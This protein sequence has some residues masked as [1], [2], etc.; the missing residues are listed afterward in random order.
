[1][2]FKTWLE[3]TKGVVTFDF[4]CTL[5]VPVWDAENELWL[6]GNPA[7][8]NHLNPKNIERLRQYARDGYT[9][10]IV[11]SRAP[12]G[13]EEEEV[14]QTVERLQ[15]PVADVICTG[16]NKGQALSQLNSLVHHDDM[17]QHHEDPSALFQGRWEKMY[18]PGDEQRKMP[19]AP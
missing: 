6:P 12:G 11:S 8:P 16:G 19:N 9:V 13:S 3:Q 2:R 14:R 17:H 18:H 10:V 5:T 4:D 7:D 1:M 15:L